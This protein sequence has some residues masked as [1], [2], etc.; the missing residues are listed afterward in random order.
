MLK[1]IRHTLA[2]VAALG[3]AGAIAALSL[4]AAN[5]ATA[6]PAVKSY[7]VTAVTKV[8][9]RPDSGD[10]GNWADDSF[11]RTAKLHLVSQVATSYCGDKTSHCYHWQGS[12]ADSGT[13]A[14]IVGDTSPGNGDLNGGSPAAIGAVVK[15]SMAGTYGYDFYAS[16]KTAKTSLVPTKEND[17]GNVPGGQQTT[18]AW[19]EQFFGSGA[20]FFVG[21]VAS[22]SLGTTGSWKYTAPFGAD[23][24]CPAAA[25]SWTDASP[26]WGANAGDGNILAPSA[27]NC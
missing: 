3:A 5:A 16:W 24:A 2:A 12:V 4:T 27:A 14:T 11:T 7:S 13:F 6:R 26:D 15:G 19:A 8:S 9:D 23:S 25:S 20:R 1:R 18:D 22:D 17:Q 21:G 10:H